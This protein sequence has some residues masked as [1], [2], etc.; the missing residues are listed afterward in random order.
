MTR[1][2]LAVALLAVLAIPSVHAQ[3]SPEAP[4]ERASTLDTLIVTGTRVADRTVAESQ[5]PID[6]ISSEALQATGTV[7]LA[8]ALA[9]A[10]P[11][12][13]FPRPALTDGT[14]AI[15]PAQLRGLAPDQVLV[16]VNGKRRHTS[17]L[18]NL[19][20]TIGRGSSPVDLNTIPISAIDRVEVLRDGASAQY[21]SDAIAGV[22]NV[23][24]KGARQGGSLSTSVG[25]YS[26][27]DGAQG[28]IAGDT[29]LAL[30]EDRGFLHLSAQLGRQDSTNR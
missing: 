17:S 26:A 18:L 4:A 22:V 20:G 29:G 27:G 28:Q 7:E 6:I 8:T 13:N 3:T 5:S 10:L 30:G 23:V 11:S 2:P 1:H 19:N 15:R 14:S 12:L 24:L 21:G 25:Q 9:R 16:L